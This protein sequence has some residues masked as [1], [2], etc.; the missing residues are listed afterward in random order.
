MP[1][2]MIHIAVANEVNKKL[3]RNSADFLIG[4]IAPDISKEV[5]WSREKSHFIDNNDGIP[6]VD[7][8]L[9]KYSSYL[10]DDFVLGY[11]VHLYTDYL[12]FK[13]FLTEIRGKDF[14][15][16][17]DGTVIK[18]TGRMDLIYI[19][20]DYTNLNIRLIDYYNLDLKIFY[21]DV[22]EFKNIIKEIPMDKINVIVN[23]VGEVIENTKVHKDMVFNMDNVKL[24]IKTSVELIL[25]NLKDIGVL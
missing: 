5:G 2:S 6:N 7:L 25:A 24:F 23:K 10:D 1:S 20:N 4:S 15:T 3:K 9:N 11:Y 8:F 22:P 16:K 18:Y 12:W 19:Y 13:Y 14:I 17:L 21:N